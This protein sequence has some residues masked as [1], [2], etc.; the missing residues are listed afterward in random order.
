M[1]SSTVQML[2]ENT[3]GHSALQYSATRRTVLFKPAVNAVSTH[4]GTVQFVLVITATI[5]VAFAHD[6]SP[7]SRSLCSCTYHATCLSPP[8]SLPPDGRLPPLD[9]PRS[10]RGGR[11]P[12]SPRGGVIPAFADAPQ[13]QPEDQQQHRVDPVVMQAPGVEDE[14]ERETDDCEQANH[15]NSLLQRQVI[16]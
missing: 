12:S 8:R 11:L 16:V 9:N 10:G 15:N 1:N 7:D 13:Q 4:R 6:V 3:L 5:A 14:R 2:S